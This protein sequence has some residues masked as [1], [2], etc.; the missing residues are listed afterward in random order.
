MASITAQILDEVSKING[1]M[2]NVKKG[3]HINNGASFIYR[4]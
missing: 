2:S 3:R 4:F 1:E